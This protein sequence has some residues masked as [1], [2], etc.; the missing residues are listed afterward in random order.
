MSDRMRP[1]PFDK[2]VDKVFEEWQSHCTIFGIPGN[3]FYRH[4]KEGQSIVTL[5]GQKLGSPIGPAAGP[6]SQLSQNI[7]AAYLTGSRF[8]ELKTV[9]KLDGEDLPVS[10]PC[11]LAEDE[12]YNVEWSTELRV[13][14]AYEEYLKAWF[15]LH[16]LMEELELSKER[17]FL[18][19]MSVGYDLEGIK[20]PKI[21]EY[22]EGMRSAKETAVWKECRRV[23]Q[24]RMNSFQHFTQEKLDR[25][26]DNV[27]ESIT[28]STLHGCPPEEIERI[29]NY[30]LKE[31]KLHTYIKMNP[32]LLGEEFVRNTF[33]GM[34]YDYITLN[35]HH[36]KN[37]LQYQDGVDMLKRLRAQ[38][39]ELSLSLGVKLTNTLPTRI[40]N[41]ELPG[42]EMYLSGRA[43]YPLTIQLAAR[44]SQE[45]DGDLSISYSGGAD[46]FNLDKILTTGI[47]PV[48]VATTI[49]KPGGYARLTQLAEKAE[50]LSKRSGTTLD[51]ALLMELA[52]EALTDP[53]HIKERRPVASRKLDSKLPLF[54][55][56]IAPCT[57]GCPIN[58]QIPEYISLVGEKKYGEAF[59]VIAIDNALPAITGSIC[60]HKCQFK[61][62]RLDYDESVWIRHMKKLAVVN[63][64]DAF[65]ENI[66]ATGLRTE[67]RVAV[68]GA[69]PAG[70]ATAYFLRRNGI[71]VKVFE[72]RESPFGVVGHI[73]P[74]FRIDKEMLERDFELVKRQGVEFEFNTNGIIDLD[75]LKKEFDYVIL[76]V[77]ALKHSKLGLMSGE[78]KAVNAIDF[79][80]SF[81]KHGGTE[82]GIV[83]KHV[84][85]IGGGDVA[86][87]AARAAKRLSGQP[88]VSIIY[89]RTRKYMPAELEEL[90][91][92]MEEG[93]ILKELLSP[94][95]IVEDV[96]VCEEMALGEKDAKGRRSPVGTGR[97][98]EL[99]TDLVIAAVG[100]QVDGE[101]MSSLGIDINSR[102]I[103]VLTSQLQ[104]NLPNV[105]VGGDG[106]SG[107]ATI[108][109]AIA[110]GKVIAADILRK[111]GLN[112]DFHAVELPMNETG[113]YYKKGLLSDGIDNESEA[114]RCLACNHV[115]ELCVDVCPNRANVL[116]RD[117]V[118]HQIAHID[119]MCNECGN[120]GT[121]CPHDGNPYKDK[122]TIFW[123]EADFEDSSNQGFVV[124]DREKGIVRART[125]AVHDG[126]FSIYEKNSYPAEFV[127][128]IE[129]CC[130]DY[131]YL[132]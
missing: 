23:L 61:C 72:K 78:E 96:L 24:G 4:H 53:H 70:L 31:K 99:K 51:M 46:F 104:T 84:C 2:L 89:R 87:D 40:E 86:M 114:S 21:N 85:V 63:A 110:D 69:G 93:I 101:A 55:C 108:V 64:Q 80:E 122:L 71:Y 82:E 88:E 49:L 92:A 30:L 74:D 1:I 56:A 52:E 59:E 38:A 111:E 126:V 15:M 129:I 60:D 118:N 94:V 6:N 97:F 95:K 58:A 119:G 3:K 77:G 9:Q 44:L 8:I 45:F 66:K 113:L 65:N 120:C 50:G 13:Q 79:L 41:G 75:Q 130:L 19:N 100:E 5:F 73:V 81:K 32:T 128:M 47:L 14:E 7:I 106:K 115:C 20:L 117:G 22:I 116:I 28:L 102:G 62:T 132:L 37:D 131:G 98:V 127:H 33:D 25:I 26:S 76:A 39:K 54:D 124:L 11:I 12:G 121:F 105:Y 90:E 36:F 29:A 10:K 34:G 43:L 68:I 83:R 42:E 103:P 107:P 125:E 48:T 57:V 35:G 27:C 123:S 16:V 67:K 112:G 17:D 18:F 109:K 91:L